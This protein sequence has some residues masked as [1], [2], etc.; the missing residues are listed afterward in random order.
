MQYILKYPPKMCLY[1]AIIKMSFLNVKKFK[2][3]GF[4]TNKFDLNQI[5]L[6]CYIRKLVKCWGAGRRW[7]LW[8][9]C[10][11]QEKW[12]FVLLVCTGCDSSALQRGPFGD[13]GTRSPSVIARLLW[14]D[15][16]RGRVLSACLLDNS[17]CRE[18]ALWPNPFNLHWEGKEEFD[19]IA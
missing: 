1:R 7:L 17:K 19:P 12:Q 5:H 3:I 8:L 16:W 11:S 2:C 10:I 6:E 18:W 4:I 15:F 9:N 13:Y 14:G